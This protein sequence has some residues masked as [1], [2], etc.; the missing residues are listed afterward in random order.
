MRFLVTLASILA[1]S[2][3]AFSQGMPTSPYVLDDT[4]RLTVIEPTATGL[5]VVH[6]ENLPTL[7]E[8][9]ERSNEINI[10]SPLWA[11]CHQTVK[12]SNIGA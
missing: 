4:F 11:V 1:L 3:P 7:E 2:T 6:Q 9:I 5:N 8:C 12:P 10:N